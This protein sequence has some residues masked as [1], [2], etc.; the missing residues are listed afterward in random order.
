MPI[1]EAALR[2]TKL[3]DSHFGD[4]SR[5]ANSTRTDLDDLPRDEFREGIVAINQTEQT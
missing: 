4:L 1:E 5:I 2:K 3:L